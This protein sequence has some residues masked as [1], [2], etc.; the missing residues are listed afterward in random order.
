MVRW[1]EPF[2]H[3]SSFAHFLT[4]R[5]LL[6]L[7]LQFLLLLLLPAAAAASEASLSARY[8][9]LAIQGDLRP[10]THL[11]ADIDS[12][13]SPTDRALAAAFRARFIG[14]TE[15]EAP[16][17]GNPLVDRVIMAYRAY[18]REALVGDDLTAAPDDRLE[19]SLAA[20]LGPQLALERAGGDGVYSTLATALESAGFRALV[21]D[22]PPLRDLFVWG[23]QETRAYDVE[24]TDE[25]R[26]VRVAF[27]SEFQSQGWKHYASLGLASTSGWVEGD[28]LY[29]VDWAYAPDSEAFRVSY[30]KHETRHLADLERFPGLSSA[31]LEYRAKLTELAYATTT[32]PRLVTDFRAK[33]ADNPDSPHAAANFRVTQ[34]LAQALFG[35]ADVA[36]ARWAALNASEVNRVA[37]RLLAR[38]TLRLEGEE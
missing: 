30:L 37:R 17:S 2:S 18:W 27:L 1:L 34:Q 15:T 22:A 10:A 14:S 12:S 3:Y 31:E 29:C 4:M 5:P 13:A 36:D 21:S 38:D 19:A 28:T 16:A 23:R 25:S 9:A 32:L 11:F 26:R 24:L 20:A 6:S 35:D 7:A 33:A 8:A